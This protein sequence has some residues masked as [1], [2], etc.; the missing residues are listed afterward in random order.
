[1]VSVYQ[2]DVLGSSDLVKERDNVKEKCKTLER[3]NSM[4]EKEFL[5][6]RTKAWLANSLQEKVDR[7]NFPPAL[8]AH[9]SKLEASLVER[10]K[11]WKK[12]FEDGAEVCFKFEV[13]NKALQK[14]KYN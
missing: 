7:Y 6:P 1:M 2:D 11:C 12:V 8:G 14:K 3:E 13:G 5:E 9:I 4:A 10:G